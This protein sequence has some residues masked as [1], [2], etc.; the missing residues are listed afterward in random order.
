[1]ILW[2][3]D[4]C[5]RAAFA[6][7]GRCFFDLTGQQTP[8]RAPGFAR[9]ASLAPLVPALGPSPRPCLGSLTSAPAAVADL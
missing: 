8:V 9:A 5:S 1:M 7:T 3:A 4:V 6:Q 2:A